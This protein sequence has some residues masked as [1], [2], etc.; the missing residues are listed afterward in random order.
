MGVYQLKVDYL[1]TE[2]ALL[3]PCHI[4]ERKNLNIIIIQFSADP[5]PYV[6]RYVFHGTRLFEEIHATDDDAAVRRNK[7]SKLSSF[8]IRPCIR[9]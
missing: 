5:A 3:A 1:C 9:Y 8:P 4:I 2:P 6:K 7:S